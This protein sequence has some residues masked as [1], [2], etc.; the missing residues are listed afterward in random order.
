MTLL[1]WV[2]W[3]CPSVVVVGSDRPYSMSSSSMSGLGE[4][5][6]YKLYVCSPVLP[7]KRLQ[8][9]L[10]K[11]KQNREVWTQSGQYLI[12]LDWGVT[13]LVH[14]LQGLDLSPYF[15]SVAKSKE[16]KMSSPRTNPINWI[17]A[18]GEYTG[19]PSQSFD[20]VSIAYVVCIPWPTK[21]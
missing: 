4:M 17:H 6:Y 14:L 7:C 16:K 5:M 13:F 20:L 21:S 11:E 18:N 15:L 9:L 12:G 19:L 2:V 3:I 10:I 1:L 8:C